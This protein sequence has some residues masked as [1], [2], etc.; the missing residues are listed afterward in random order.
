VCQAGRHE[1]NQ[2]TVAVKA[3]QGQRVEFS[4]SWTWV[5]L[6]VSDLLYLFHIIKLQYPSHRNYNF[7]HN[8]VIFFQIPSEVF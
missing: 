6:I 8:V 4:T 7:C 5:S 1:Q 3:V 2:E